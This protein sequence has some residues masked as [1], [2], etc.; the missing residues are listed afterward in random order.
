MLACVLLAIGPV[1]DPGAPHAA[2]V[3][4]PR[5]IDV[6]KIE[7]HLAHVEETLRSSSPHDAT[8]AALQAR[9]RALD[10]LHDYWKAGVFPKNRDFPDRR[11]PYFID[12]DGTAC[13]VG[14]LM[15]A[16]GDE[17][18][19][20]EIATYENNDFLADID[21]PGVVPWLVRNGLTASEAAWIQPTYG[22]CGAV[23]EP[24]CGADGNSYSCEYY[25][26]ECAMVEVAAMD[27][28]EGDSYDDIVQPE[29]PDETTGSASETESAGSVTG[30]DEDDDDDKKGCRVGDPSAIAAFVPLIVMLRR[31]RSALA[32]RA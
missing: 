21:H 14:H 3:E 8:P 15:I 30:D 26:T 28:C 9:D 2:D 19:A 31:R 27:L 5:G 23:G 12:A 11:V 4:H 16:S 13:A 10:A 25:A 24:V 1:F 17:A 6:A 7:R 29:C 18:L 32:G 22:P 20:R